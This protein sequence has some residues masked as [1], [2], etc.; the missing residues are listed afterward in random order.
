MLDSTSKG[1]APYPYPEEWV[2]W[3]PGS[4]N[5]KNANADIFKD[6]YYL[7]K[8]AM[9]PNTNANKLFWFFYNN[10]NR[11]FQL[12]NPW[13]KNLVKLL[14]PKVF[15]DVNLVK[16]LVKS[17]K[18]STKTFYNEDSN[19]LCCLDKNTVVEAFGLGGPMSKKVDVEYFK[20]RF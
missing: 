14:A 12:S 9:V 5:H 13:E 18:P 3:Y 10:K 15:V 16:T 4:S 17:Y 11:G 1:S 20:K 2:H 7:C 6:V 19:I 8:D